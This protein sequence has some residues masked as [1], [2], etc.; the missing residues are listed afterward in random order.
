M[1]QV[2]EIEGYIRGLDRQIAA[3]REVLASAR[4]FEVGGAAY[5]YMVKHGG[6]TKEAQEMAESCAAARVVTEDGIKQLLESRGQL[7]AVLNKV[8]S[9]G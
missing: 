4:E 3:Y 6:L 7:T 8:R 1:D 9:S 2:E 5:E